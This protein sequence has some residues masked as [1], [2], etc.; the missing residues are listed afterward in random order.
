ML[1]FNASVALGYLLRYAVIVVSCEFYICVFFKFVPLSV[2]L[3]F[4]FSPQRIGCALLV[5]LGFYKG[6]AL[7]FVGVE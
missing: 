7:Y 2:S 3:R 4:S 6:T 1:T 5:L